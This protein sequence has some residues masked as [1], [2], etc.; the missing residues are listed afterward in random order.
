LRLQNKTVVVQ[1]F[2]FEPSV[3]IGGMLTDVTRSIRFFVC[4]VFIGME[5]V[6]VTPLRRSPASSP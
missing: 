5:M 2:C 4:I 6:Q 3:N 1:L